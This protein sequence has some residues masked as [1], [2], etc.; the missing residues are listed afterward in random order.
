MN[1]IFL[2]LTGSFLNN[3]AVLSDSLFDIFLY[4]CEMFNCGVKGMCSPTFLHYQSV[5]NVYFLSK[6]RFKK[7]KLYLTSNANHN[8]RTDYGQ[9]GVHKKPAVLCVL[10]VFIVSGTR[11]VYLFSLLR[12]CGLLVQPQFYT[13]CLARGESSCFS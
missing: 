10:S 12:A 3:Y 2:T 9:L 6:W 5:M 13:K 8:I 4:K 7:K 1:L 11:L